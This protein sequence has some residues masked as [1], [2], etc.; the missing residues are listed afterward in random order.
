MEAT[1]RTE[2]DIATNQ[3]CPNGDCDGF[4]CRTSLKFRAIFAL[5]S[6]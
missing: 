1:M 5:F 2:H 4:L 3:V 6:F